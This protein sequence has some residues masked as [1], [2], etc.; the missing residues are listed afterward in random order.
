MKRATAVFIFLAA[1]LLVYVG[2][3]GV[4]WYFEPANRAA[5][6]WYEYP[7]AAAA[8]GLL[9]FLAASARSPF[10]QVSARAFM[11]GALLLF[12]CT[13]L[14]WV[15]LV[16]TQ[17]VN[18][19]LVLHNLAGTLS[20]GQPIGGIGSGGNWPIFMYAWGYSLLLGGFY[21]VFGKAVLVAKLL[22]VAL[23]ACTLLAIYG[24]VRQLASERIGRVS[25]AFFLAWPTQITMTNVVAAEHVSLAAVAA[26]FWLLPAGLRELDPDADAVK[27]PW[28]RTLAA[29]ALLGVAYLT[30]FPMLVALIASLMTLVVAHG[31]SRRL[32]I[33]ASAAVA[34]FLAINVAFAVILATVYQV[35]LPGRSV[36]GN[37]LVGVNPASGGAW[38]AEDSAKLVAFPTFEAANAWAMEESMRRI[39]ASPGGTVRLM[40]KKAARFWRTDE[41][42]LWWGVETSV[43]PEAAA[44][45]LRLLYHVTSFYH[46]GMLVLG[47]IGGVWLAFGGPRQPGLNL[48]VLPL[49]GGTL[50]H[51]LLEVQTRYHYPFEPILFVLAAAGAVRLFGGG[52]VP[53][54]GA[55]QPEGY[56]RP[57][58]R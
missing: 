29:G 21:A 22:N 45:Y 36:A 51:S 14:L 43:P 55:S 52:T 2:G 4:L 20:A 49:I 1:A 32:L 25:A 13:R 27:R 47:A 42:G 48:V 57:E 31:F 18:D 8:L 53:Q 30:R 23:G 38:N 40:V 34:G 56:R 10:A 24:W 46:S 28:T 11:A 41:Y 44:H 5:F 9:I 3:A 33:D 7:L 6:S 19:F 12:L 54:G 17:P 35:R 50:L 26:A 16:P 39:R 37:L 58:V 15:L